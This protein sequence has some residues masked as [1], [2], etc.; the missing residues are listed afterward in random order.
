MF[1]IEVLLA[2]LMLLTDASSLHTGKIRKIAYVKEQAEYV[3][4]SMNWPMLENSFCRNYW[5]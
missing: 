4:T 1:Q 3:A 5:Q 2:C